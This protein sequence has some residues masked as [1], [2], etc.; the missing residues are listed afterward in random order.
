MSRNSSS[1]SSS[2]QGR[3]SQHQS[4]GSGSVHLPQCGCG[5]E[6]PLLTAWTEHNPGRRFRMCQ[7][8][9][10]HHIVVYSIGWIQKF[11]K[12]A[13]NFFLTRTKELCV[14]RMTSIGSTEGRKV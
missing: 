7:I 9:E 11:V 2:S 3:R 10:N 13:K 4:S 6:L 1:N 12:G 14:W 8:T 5:F